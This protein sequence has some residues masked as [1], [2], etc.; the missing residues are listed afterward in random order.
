MPTLP[1]PGNKGRA[2]AI[3]AKNIEIGLKILDLQDKAKGLIKDVE[4]NKTSLDE[5]GDPNGKWMPFLPIKEKNALMDFYVGLMPQMEKVSE[6]LQKMLE[7]SDQI[8]ANMAIRPGAFLK[9]FSKAAQAMEDMLKVHKQRNF[10][11]FMR[12]YEK[13]FYYG[14]RYGPNLE[15]LKKR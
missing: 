6:A 15:K 9:E 8:M 7:V 4:S 2:D 3:M 5:L 13:W 12:M 1:D 11:H 10:D 14:I